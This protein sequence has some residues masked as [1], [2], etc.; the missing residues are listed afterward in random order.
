MTINSDSPATGLGAGQEDRDP[1]PTPRRCIGAQAALGTYRD[2]F[3]TGATIP[4]EHHELTRDEWERLYPSA[5][6]Q[7]GG[8]RNACV[9]DGSCVF[10]CRRCE[11][12]ACECNG[13]AASDV[14]GEGDLCS[15]CRCALQE[16]RES[17]VKKAPKRLTFILSNSFDAYVKTVHLNCQGSVHRR[18]V[19]IELTDEQ[20]EMLEP[21]KTGS[22]NGVD[23][24]E[25]I[26]DCI[27]EPV[28]VS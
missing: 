5:E 23:Q 12:W 28:E 10:L 20:R 2:Q 11:R 6:L 8:K 16:E 7:H 3:P 17:T 22:S 4:P 13:S 25:V 15:D 9:G 19:R 27:I 14:D 26:D 1:R 24:Y 21:R 18:T